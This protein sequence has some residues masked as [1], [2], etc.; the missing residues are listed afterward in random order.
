VEKSEGKRQRRRPGSR[1]QDDMTMY[2]QGNIW[3]FGLN[4][5]IYLNKDTDMWRVFLKAEIKII[6]LKLGGFL[7]KLRYNCLLKNC[8]SM[9]IDS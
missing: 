6:S 9:E 7:E 2:L 5:R 8:Y 4:I 3:G 1:W